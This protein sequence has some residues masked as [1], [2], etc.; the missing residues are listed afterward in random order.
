MPLTFL[1]NQQGT[2]INETATSGINDKFGWWNCIAA[3]DIDNDGKMD[4]I[5]GN[6]EENSFFKGDSTF[7]INNYFNDFD[8]N[9]RF[10][11]ITTKYLKD[12]HGNFK[13]YSAENHD[14]IMV[15]LPVLKKQFLSYKN[16]GEATIDKLFTTTQF[17]GTIKSHANYFV[18]SYI[19][20]LG[21]GKFELKPLPILAQLAPVFGICINDYNKDG[22]A[23]ILLCGNDYGAEVSNGRL[24]ASDG[25]V[26]KGNSKGDFSPLLIQQSGIYVPGDARELVKLKYKKGKDLYI[27][28][29]NKGSLKVYTL[30]R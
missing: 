24:D 4:Y 5:A 21:N 16:F 11:S 3:V 10:E 29:Q 2:F 17:A 20:N 8:K 22:N 18:S 13:E 14:E 30:K 15:Q 7:P 25:L 19:H 9:G 26:L 28:S 6:L 23:D 1:K 27:V 12:Q